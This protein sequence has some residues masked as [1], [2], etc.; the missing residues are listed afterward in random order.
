MAIYLTPTDTP[1]TST[2]GGVYYD[3]SEKG[4]KHYNGTTWA[5]IDGKPILIG[6]EMGDIPLMNIQ[7]Y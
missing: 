3:N 6:P 7:F 4:L 1:P 2:T 5:P